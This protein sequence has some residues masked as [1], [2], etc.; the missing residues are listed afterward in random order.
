ETVAKE[1]DVAEYRECLASSQDSLG[2]RRRQDGDPRMALDYHG[3]ARANVAMLVERYPDNADYA[4]VFANTSYNIGQAERALG[5]LDDALRHFEE[6]K[7]IRERLLRQQP[8]SAEYRLVLAVTHGS[9]GATQLAA[10]KDLGA[11]LLAYE[12]ARDVLEKVVAENPDVGNYADSLADIY[13]DIS[14]VQPSP[15]PP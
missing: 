2:V 6:A 3:E 5:R 12:S 4:N 1:P 9:I 10:G 13:Y 15:D 8:Q 14:R 11:A 7:L